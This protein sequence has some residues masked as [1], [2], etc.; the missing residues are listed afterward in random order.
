MKKK[1]IFSIAVLMTV[2]LTV[3]TL[4]TNA[5]S[6]DVTAIKK[7]IEEESNAYFHKNYD[8]WLKT[9][10]HDSADVLLRVAPD[11]YYKLLGWNEIAAEYKTDIQH[12]PAMS[13][14]DI[15]PLVHKTDYDIKLNGNMA[16]AGFKNGKSHSIELR[17]LVK[18]NGSWKILTLTTINSPAYAMRTTINRMKAFAGKWVLE[19]K[20][21][22]EP[23]TGVDLNSLKFN[24]RITP[25]GLK[26]FSTGTFSKNGKLL[27]SPT[28]VEYFIPD[29]DANTISYM[30]I[31]KVSTGQTYTS[32][33]NVTSTKPNSFTV[34]IMYKD[35]PTAVQSEFTATMKDGEW[36]Q[37][38]KQFDEDGKQTATTTVTL[39]RVQ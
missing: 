26:Q 37:V 11:N 24:L 17:T 22:R 15:D 34:T 33:G 10:A 8:D 14:A 36:Y 18:Q 39:R 20:A 28:E 38:G 29:Y 6:K 5:Q 35:K 27:S 9:W 16:S 13:E 4:K 32:M 3:S 31:Y 2:C 21:T 19:G 1:I 30:S 25:D 12:L 7:V 23:S